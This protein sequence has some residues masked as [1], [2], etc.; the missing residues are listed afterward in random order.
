MLTYLPHAFPHSHF[1]LP[2][3]CPL[4]ATTRGAIIPIF[5]KHIPGVA[6]S[7]PRC[8]EVRK[9]GG[10]PGNSNAL[11]HGLYSTHTPRPRTSP[12]KSSPSQKDPSGLLNDLQN[13]L[14]AAHK[15]DL[16]ENR[17]K[18]ADCLAASMGGLPHKEILS[19]VRAAT[20]IV[21]KNL[22]AIRSI[23]ELGGRQEHLRSIVGDLPALLRWEFSG[24]G[25]PV[26]SAFVPQK[27][28]YLHA[29][30]SWESPHLTNAQWLV[31]KETFISLHSELDFP[32]KYHRRKP[33]PPDRFLLEGI[34]WKLANGLRWRDL[35]DKYS[36]RRCQE[37][38]SALY[39]SERMQIVYRQLQGFLDVHGRSALA[40]LVEH[41][42]F[43]I[44]G[45]RVLLA[46]IE[47][48][49]WEKYTALL[50]LQQGYHARRSIRHAVDRERRRQGNYF[51]LPP[52]RVPDPSCRSAR[53][54]SHPPASSDS[55]LPHL[56]VPPYI[57]VPL[58]PIDSPPAGGCIFSNG[59]FP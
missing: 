28:D 27:L 59:D 17:Q 36:V 46:P 16:R 4:P 56:Q 2:S 32:R 48:P 18:L 45:N 1:D 54:P 41:G 49:T 37:L 50:L 58:S 53:S 33:L 34:L 42:C 30:L 55:K 29:N 22:K 24:R 57:Y 44:S 25:I 26:Q 52:H 6:V 13:G 3:S 12:L 7:V 20:I 35:A 9:R 10:Q 31:L 40:E 39:R 8:A 14:I 38:Y 5:M 19:Q 43:V 51:R 23:F 15:R 21:G 47:T 11:R